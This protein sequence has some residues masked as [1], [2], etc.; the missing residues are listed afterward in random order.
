MI[1]AFLLGQAADLLTTV[2]AI[3]RFGL[4]EGN[5]LV[6][7]L[8]V[9][10]LVAVK[11]LGVVFILV[12]SNLTPLRRVLLWSGAAAGVVAAVWNC[13]LMIGAM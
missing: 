10:D 3:A 1:P 2:V 6:A 4:R 5:P 11:V 13:H 9:S 7:H 12:A 8:S